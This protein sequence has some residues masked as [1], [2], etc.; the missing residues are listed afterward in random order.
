MKRLV[1]RLLRRCGLALPYAD[2]IC[3]EHAKYLGIDA[4]G[5]ARVTV[6]KK[7][8]F[9]NVPEDGDLFDT[10][11]LDPDVAF[12]TFRLNS[13]DASEIGRRR[14]GRKAIAVEWKPRSPITRYAL[15]DHEYSWA[16]QGAFNQDAV[17]CEFQCEETRTGVFLFEMITPQE[18]SAA[19]VF[20]RP[21]WTRLNTERKLLKYALK[22]LDGNAERPG[23]VDNGQRVSWKILG[24]KKNVRYICVAFHQNGVILWKDR[25]KKSSLTGGIRQLVERFS[26]K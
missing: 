13:P 12:E 6:Q 22:Q 7:L 14:V 20:E 3:A 8:V 21:R 18:F 24:P 19:V 2:V 11:P 15:Y 25:L 10:C 1:R 4:T 5:Q 9:L 26:F 16:P 23:I 17:W